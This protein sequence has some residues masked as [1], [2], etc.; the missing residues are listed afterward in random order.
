MRL[1][2]D[3]YIQIMLLPIYEETAETVSI[4]HPNPPIL[5][6][7]LKPGDTLRPPAPL[8]SEH[9]FLSGLINTIGYT[10]HILSGTVKYCSNFH[11][12]LR[13]GLLVFS[14][15][16]PV[17]AT[18]AGH[19]RGTGGDIDNGIGITERGAGWIILGLDMAGYI[20]RIKTGRL[21]YCTIHLPESARARFQSR[22]LLY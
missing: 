13:N 4:N 12:L 9:L 20:N 8:L 22:A 14:N 2:L 6:D 19:P 18:I 1:E 3:Y 11:G 17:L 16:N 5:G 7:C 21:N 10:Y 15:H